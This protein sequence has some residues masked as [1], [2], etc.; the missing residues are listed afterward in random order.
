[1]RNLCKNSIGLPAVP[2]S[3]TSVYCPRSQIHDWEVWFTVV[4]SLQWALTRTGWLAG[5]GALAWSRVIGGVTRTAP[6]NW[7]TSR[8]YQRPIIAFS[9]AFQPP[10]AARTS[11]DHT[12]IAWVASEVSQHCI[13]WR[14]SRLGCNTCVG[15]PDH[16]ACE[17]S[18]SVSKSVRPTQMWKPDRDGRWVGLR[19]WDLSGPVNWM[20]WVT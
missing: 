3:S 4:N 15:H 9:S 8:D 5:W 11:R 14:P 7:H 2:L 10:W 13:W 6:D 18:C 16:W 20:A 1:M 19:H 12:K 17:V